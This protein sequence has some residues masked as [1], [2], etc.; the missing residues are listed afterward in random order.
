MTH[1]MGTT[2]SGEL[3]LAELLAEGGRELPERALLRHR[4]GSRLSVSNVN[5]TSQVIDNPQ[6]AIGNGGPV[7]QVGANSNSNTTNQGGTVL[8]F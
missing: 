7:T 2:T 3:G 5:S 6:I 4:R 8:G 1:E